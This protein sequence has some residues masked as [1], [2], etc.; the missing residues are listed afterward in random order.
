MRREILHSESK[1]EFFT[2]RAEAYP[3]Y[4]WIEVE[5]LGGEWNP[6]QQ[7]EHPHGLAIIEALTGPGGWGVEMTGDGD[8]IVWARLEIAADT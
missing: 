5:D 1:G 3:G 7:D 6:R 4:V 8:R 2:V